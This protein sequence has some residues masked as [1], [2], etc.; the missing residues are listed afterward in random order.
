MRLIDR[1]ATYQRQLPSLELKEQEIVTMYQN[2]PGR[3]CHLRA[4]L[5]RKPSPSKI[6]NPKLLS[7]RLLRNLFPQ[8]ALTVGQLKRPLT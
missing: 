3:S 7:Q 8:P 4:S 2:R 1:A 6:P 5:V